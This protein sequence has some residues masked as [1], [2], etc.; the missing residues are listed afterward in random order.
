[1]KFYLK[2][3]FLVQKLL[4][5]LLNEAVPMNHNFLYKKALDLLQKS[6]FP[7]CSFFISLLMTEK[8]ENSKGMRAIDYVREH[9]IEQ[10]IEE[11]IG[12]VVHERPNDPY[13]VL[14][15]SFASQSDP[16][17]IHQIK[18]REILLSTGRP[19]LLVEVYFTMRVCWGEFLLLV[20]QVLLWVLLF[21][22]R[23]RSLI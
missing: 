13:G 12:Q 9:C 15:N 22:V 19:T 17:I 8:E 6:S 11:F 5:I 7:K 16:P 14:A 18:G 1:L 10:K 21:L 20:L 23:N 3:K 2:K 4:H